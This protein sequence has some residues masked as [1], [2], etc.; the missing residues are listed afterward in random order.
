MEE[1]PGDQCSGD[2]G[3]P[4]FFDGAF[5]VVMALGSRLGV[6]DGSR[7]Q[8][9]R[10]LLTW[11]GGDRFLGGTKGLQGAAAPPR[12]LHATRARDRALRRAK[13]F[14]DMPPAAQSCLFF[15]WKEP[16]C[17]RWVGAGLDTADSIIRW[18]VNTG[19]SEWVVLEESSRGR[20]GGRPASVTGRYR[21]LHGPGH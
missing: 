17:K 18:L 2:P 19:F 10:W 21:R 8:V 9:R 4:G 5:V 20:V 6:H 14:W 16:R 7:R 12:G 13:F 3:D 15:F 11:G 1:T